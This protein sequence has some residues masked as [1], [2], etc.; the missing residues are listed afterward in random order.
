MPEPRTPPVQFRN[1]DVEG[2]IAER[3]GHNLSAGTVA[4][5]DL[6]RYYSLLDSELPELSPNEWN[7]LRDALNGTLTETSSMKMLWLDAAD[8]IALD[9]LA[10]KWDVDGKAL[11]ERLRSFS[12]AQYYAVADAVERWWARQR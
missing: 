5:R 1:A 2:K 8:A 7:L 9:S 3:T 10:E 12:L 11:V 4:A 6:E